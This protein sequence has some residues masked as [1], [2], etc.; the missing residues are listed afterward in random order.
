MVL[1][2]LERGAKP[3]AMTAE[4]HSALMLAARA[5]SKKDLT[6]VSELQDLAEAVQLLEKARLA[7]IEA[8]KKQAEQENRG[9][10]RSKRDRKNVIGGEGKD[11]PSSVPGVKP[12]KKNAT[13][14]QR[15]RGKGQHLLVMK[16]LLGVNGRAHIELE[17]LDG[18]RALHHAADRGHS[19][20]VMLLLRSGAATRRRDHHGRLPSD[21]AERSGRVRLADILHISSRNV[22]PAHV[23][24]YHA[25]HLCS[26]SAEAEADYTVDDSNEEKL[27]AMKGTS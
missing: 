18:M 5:C 22:D 26:G 1:L 25:R 14:G 27:A 23:L 4:G 2:L 21:L 9:R 11:L 8:D 24:K 20:A 19:S 16:V 6:R 7:A 17:D 12:E 10:G 13:H 15:N 3:D